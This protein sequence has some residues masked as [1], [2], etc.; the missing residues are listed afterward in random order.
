MSNPDS[1]TIAKRIPKK[2][3]VAWFDD[4]DL[5]TV[6]DQRPSRKTDI[7]NY[8]VEG[9]PRRMYVLAVNWKRGKRRFRVVPITSK[10]KDEKGQLRDDR[11]SIGRC[12]TEEKDSFFRLPPEEHSEKLICRRDGRSPVV[13]PCN[14]LAFQCA[15]KVLEARLR[16]PTKV[17]DAIQRRVSDLV[18]GKP[19][20]ASPQTPCDSPADRPG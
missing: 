3:E 7:Y 19:A 10:G 8:T 20:P 14:R 2:G 9:K 15:I 11:I 16:Q 18:Q 13:E 5:D 4:L 6:R 12:I 1:Q 17:D